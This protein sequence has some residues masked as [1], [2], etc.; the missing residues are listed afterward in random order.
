MTPSIMKSSLQA[1]WNRTSMN[2]I[3]I[4][5]CLWSALSVAPYHAGANDSKPANEA[6]K[7]AA[8][9]PQP[10]GT[11]LTFSATPTMQEISRIRVFEIPLAP[12]G[13]EPS[14]DENADMA[15]ALVGYSHRSGPDDFSALTAFLEKHP[16]SSWNAA[17]LTGLGS[18]Y[19]NTAHYSLAL[20]AWSR[21]WSYAKD[22]HDSMGNATIN[23]AVS[24]LGFLYARLGRRTELEALLKSV[25]SRIFMGGEAVKINGAREG[26]WMMKNRPEVSFRCGPLAL[27]RIKLATDPEHPST[28]LIEESVSTQKGLSLSQVAELSKKAGMNYQMAFREKGSAFVVPSV[29]HW[30]VG[31]YAAMVR[32]EGDRFL[33]EDPTF[34][35]TVWATRQA[36]EAETS[37]YF[38][39]PPG[40]LPRGWRSLDAK[41]GASVWGRGATTSNDPDP[42]TPNDPK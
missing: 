30:N 33:L 18:E 39:I 31:H 1:P 12:I 17:L 23:H 25:E 21:A 34:G 26:L 20:E 35:N 22:A 10:A 9:V 19:Y 37:G 14:S 27:H 28:A 13:A 24:E 5:G 36:L 16:H 7:P 6:A 42:L 3:L 11:F 41:E 38:L 8:Q 32:Q 29:V 15:A 40:D 2:Q 4:A